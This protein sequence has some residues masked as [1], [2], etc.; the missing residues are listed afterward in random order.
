MN[1]E[2]KRREDSDV[3]SSVQ[4]VDQQDMHTLL[5]CSGDTF[6]TDMKR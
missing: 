2:L 1:G 6:P 4:V 5:N 3:S